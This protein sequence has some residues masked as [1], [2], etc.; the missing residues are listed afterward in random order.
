VVG[1]MAQAAAANRAAYHS[2]LDAH[3]HEPLDPDWA[4]TAEGTIREKLD[5]MAREAR[6]RLVSFDCRSRSCV[7]T[8]EFASYNEA[9]RGLTAVVG[10]V[11]CRSE[12]TLDD[13]PDASIPFQVTILY[14]CKGVSL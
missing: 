9:F 10:S 11:A 12:S 6:A 2:R 13:P 1:D 4:K 3:A 8:L 14:D 7:A 5:H